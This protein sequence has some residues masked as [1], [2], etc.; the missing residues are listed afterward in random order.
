MH[1]TRLPLN[2]IFQTGS[3]SAV[4]VES[5]GCLALVGIVSTVAVSPVDF[6]RDARDTET[7]SKITKWVTLTAKYSIIILRFKTVLSSMDHNDII[8]FSPLDCLRVCTLCKSQ[9]V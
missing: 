7:S 4:F 9:V 3:F 5:A 6:T 1:C 2:K 8:Y